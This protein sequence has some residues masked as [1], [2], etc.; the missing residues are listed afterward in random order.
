MSSRHNTSSGAQK[1]PAST[2]GAHQI[3][4]EPPRGVSTRRQQLNESFENL[5]NVK[6]LEK[7]RKRVEYK[8]DLIEDYQTDAGAAKL[9]DKTRK[10]NDNQNTR[11]QD[12]T[13]I[14]ETHLGK[15]VTRG[16]KG[17]EQLISTTFSSSR[18][19]TAPVN[20]RDQDPP[21]DEESKADKSSRMLV[22]KSESSK[23]GRSQIEA[24]LHELKKDT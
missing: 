22:N 1:Q 9:R 4:Q 10:L 23:L 16:E 2:R 18:R 8:A 19:N 11:R 12:L 13:D 3:Q 7:K 5:K 24:K 17:R 20:Y 6:N 15:R 14:G 21:S